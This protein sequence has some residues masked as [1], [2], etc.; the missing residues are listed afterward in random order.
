METVVDAV[1]HTKKLLPK[2]VLQPESVLEETRKVLWALLK[3]GDRYPVL[4]R[5]PFLMDEEAMLGAVPDLK[6]TVEEALEMVKNRDKAVLDALV[7]SGIVQEQ[8]DK[9]FPTA[10]QRKVRLQPCVAR[11]WLR[12]PSWQVKVASL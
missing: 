5:A 12:I 9:H 1:R 6:P 3:S 11:V 8:I 10:I 7:Q 2:K 4:N